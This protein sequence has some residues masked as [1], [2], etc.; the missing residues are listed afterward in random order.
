MLSLPTLVKANTSW[1]P[2][3]VSAVGVSHTGNTNETVIATTVIPGGAMGSNGVL[4][5]ISHWS[6]TNNGNVKTMR[7]RFADIGGTAFLST[8]GTTGLSTQVFTLIRNRNNVA[9][10]NGFA[11]GATA[12]VTATVN[13]AVAQN[14]VFTAQLATGTDTLTL[15]SLLVEV[16]RRN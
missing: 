7:I 1:V 13:T 6:F 8:T 12:P 11:G 10:Q 2:L 9:S 4:Q 3:G 15:E 5:I 16:L 14:L